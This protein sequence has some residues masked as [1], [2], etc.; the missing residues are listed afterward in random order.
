[1][2]L[3]LCCYLSKI[4]LVDAKKFNYKTQD[5]NQFIYRSKS[6]RVAEE[7]CKFLLP[8]PVL[9]WCFADWSSCLR[10]PLILFDRNWVVHGSPLSRKEAIVEWLSHISRVRSF[11]VVHSHML[12]HFL[13]HLHFSKLVL[14]HGYLRYMMFIEIPAHHLHH[15]QDLDWDV[16]SG[17]KYSRQRLFLVLEIKLDRAKILQS[18]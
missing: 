14:C 10:E 5:N 3:S 13:H 7:F 6:F 15:V 2:T 16:H 9:S 12:S 8:S 17:Q 1:M 11:G 18:T 4:K